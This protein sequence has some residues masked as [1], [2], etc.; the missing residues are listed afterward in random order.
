MFLEILNNKKISLAIFMVL[1]MVA[2]YFYLPSFEQETG[3]RKAAYL[4]QTWKLDYVYRDG[5]RVIDERNEGLEVTIL[6]DSTA[7]ERV[8]GLSYKTVFYIDKNLEYI[9]T[10]QNG[11][12]KKYKIYTLTDNTLK[13]GQDQSSTRYLFV[14]KALKK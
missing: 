7:I 2:V 11:S 10:G 1:T 13:Y 5:Q 12:P 14:L 3:P 4:Y 8:R 9:Y 6:P